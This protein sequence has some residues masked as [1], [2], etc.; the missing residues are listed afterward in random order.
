MFV[1]VG[2]KI[3]RALQIIR[4]KKLIPNAILGNNFCQVMIFRL[5]TVYNKR[6][7]I[8]IGNKNQRKIES[9]IASARIILLPTVPVGVPDE[10][11]TSYA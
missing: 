10:G 7:M 1:T 5:C 9:I 11:M 6:K 8:K 2:S 4:I 3:I